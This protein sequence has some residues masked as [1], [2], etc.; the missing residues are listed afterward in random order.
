[1]QDKYVKT[2]GKVRMDIDKKAQMRSILEEE[3]MNSNDIKPAKKTALSSGAKA[4]LAVAAAV[5]VTMGVLCLVPNTRDALYAG[6]MRLFGVE[7]PADAKDQVEEIEQNRKERVIPTDSMSEEEAKAVMSEVTK[8]DQIEDKYNNEVQVKA[9]YYSDKELNEM[10]NYFAGQHYTI[11]DLK[12]D[13]DFDDG[14]SSPLW[15]EKDGWYK[16]GFTVRY[17]V[18]DNAYGHN[19]DITVFKADSDQLKIYMTNTLNRIN[20]ERKDHGQKTVSFDDFWKESKDNEGNTVYEG[21][22]TGP[23]PSVKILDSDSARF[24]NIKVVYDQ[25]T[26][27]AVAT[28]SEGG[29]VG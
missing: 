5:T 23:D 16:E 17:R 25:D 12:K 10:A 3:L 20:Y 2:F 4:G 29:G 14:I 9:D 26:G 21:Q 27:L 13:S 19:E 8:Q 6:A 15:Q 18:G 7:I 28:V 24:D 1:M 11:F 22:W